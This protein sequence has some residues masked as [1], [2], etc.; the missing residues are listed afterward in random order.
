MYLKSSVYFLEVVTQ[1]GHL[2]SHVIESWQNNGKL[3]NSCLHSTLIL[4]TD[5]TLTLRDYW[6]VFSLWNDI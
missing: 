3:V 6:Y 5:L 2:Q 4:V 1:G